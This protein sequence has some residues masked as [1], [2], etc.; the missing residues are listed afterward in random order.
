MRKQ[1]NCQVLVIAES[2]DPTGEHESCPEVSRRV[3]A[4]LLASHTE[5]ARL[6]TARVYIQSIPCE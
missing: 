4:S 5:V 6:S 2:C 1:R 3:I